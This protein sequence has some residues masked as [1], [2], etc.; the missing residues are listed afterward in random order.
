MKKIGNDYT[1]RKLYK[2]SLLVMILTILTSTIGML[3][4]G[5]IISSFLGTEAMAA[6]GLA[7]PVFLVF[8]AVGGVLSSGAQTLCSKS[9]GSGKL[10]QANQ[11]FSLSCVLAGILSVVLIAVMMAFATPIIQALGA[12]GDEANLFQ[13]AKDYLLA[14][15][16]GIPGMLASTLLSPFM[17]LDGDRQRSL[18]SVV[19]MTAVNI[20]GDLLNV[21]VFKQGMWGMGL[22][23]TI[24]YYVAVLV[25]V[26]HFFKKDATYSFSLKGIEW[27]RTGSLL[28]TGLPTA[29]SRLCH[30][31]RTLILN[32][33]LLAI[34]SGVAV[35]AF[36]VQSN[37]NSFLGSIGTGVGMVTL[38]LSGII[39]GEENPKSAKTLF[40]TAMWYAI[41]PVGVVAILVFIFAPTL[42]SF[43]EKENLEAAALAVRGLRFYAVSMPLYGINIVFMNYLQGC[44]QLKLAHVVCIFDNFV[45]IVLTALLLGNIMGTDG[46]WIAFPIGEVLMLAMLFVIAAVKSRKVPS[47]MEDFMFL[48]QGFGVPEEE[49]MDMSI[50][51]MEQV[52]DLSRSTEAF[53]RK[54]GA[55]QRKTYLIALCIEEMAGNIVRHGFND[56]KQH[57][58][59]FRL[60]KKEDEFLISLRD[61]CRP[62][63]PKKQLEIMCPD[64]P[65]SNIGIR[66]VYGMAKE[67]NYV[68]TLKM[69][70]LFIKV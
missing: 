29:V 50:Q 9:M 17:Q 34:A 70:N 67:V 58:I 52:I 55:D 41:V 69:N 16:L 32:K 54:H 30:T 10:K 61:D 21:F 18:L 60:V 42:V 48:P 63:D 64:D 35:S 33:L 11:L 47:K 2:S 46:V 12:V 59:D 36:S 43:Y 27:K 19:A 1:I 56:G 44:R 8:S 65:C 14:L 20:A 37:L 6:Y 4:D 7:S 13:P 24:S 53:C 57:N 49:Q 3:V 39:M 15:A 22:A 62:F 40:K 23:T 31:F 51:S 5:L 66:L 45:F 28:S 38:M 68:N 26:L 25:L